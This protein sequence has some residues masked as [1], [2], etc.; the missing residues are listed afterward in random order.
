MQNKKISRSE[1]LDIP[2]NLLNIVNNNCSVSVFGQIA[3]EEVKRE[4]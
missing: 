3:F 4:I 2:E 1:C